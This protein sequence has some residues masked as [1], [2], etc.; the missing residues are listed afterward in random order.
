MKPLSKEFDQA[1][2]MMSTRT[3]FIGGMFGVAAVATAIGGTLGVASISERVRRE[4]QER[5]NQDL[6]TVHVLA[7][8]IENSA[9]NISGPD[10]NPPPG[11]TSTT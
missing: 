8:R 5:V 7:E 3:V 11:C 10:E 1:G 4:A 6:K 2:H 9:K